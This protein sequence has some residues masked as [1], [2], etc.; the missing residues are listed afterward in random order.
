MGIYAHRVHVHLADLRDVVQELRDGV[1]GG[2]DGLWS[3]GGLL[4]KPFRKRDLPGFLRSYRP[5][6][7][8]VMGSYPEGCVFYRFH[9]DPSQADGHGRAELIVSQPSDLKLNPGGIISSKRKYLI[10][11]SGSRSEMVLFMFCGILKTIVIH[12]VERQRLRSLSCARPGA[13][14]P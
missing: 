10:T 14:R 5:T 7:S 9:P 1:D 12:N 13:R 2:N 11:A 4:R 6:S 3:S 8:R